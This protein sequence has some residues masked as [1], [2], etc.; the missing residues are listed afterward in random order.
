MIEENRSSFQVLQKDIL[1]KVHEFLGCCQRTFMF[2]VIE[3]MTCP[4]GCEV[5][6]VLVGTGGVSHDDLL[7]IKEE[8]SIW[9]LD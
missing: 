2:H 8:S 7:Y 5:N 9:R 4:A 3:Y 1:L 6:K